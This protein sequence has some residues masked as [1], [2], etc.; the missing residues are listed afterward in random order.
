MIKRREFI[1]GLGSAAAWPLAVRAQQPAVPVV[2]Y[3]NTRSRAASSSRRGCVSR[4]PWQHGS[5][6]KAATLRSTTDILNTRKRV[7]ELAADL[8]RRQATVIY[9]VGGRRAIRHKARI[10]DPL[11]F[12]ATLSGT[13]NRVKL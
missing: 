9:A 3:L 10:A 11:D 2:G 7:P 4:G 6:S 5:S 13:A 1:A 8:V 12:A